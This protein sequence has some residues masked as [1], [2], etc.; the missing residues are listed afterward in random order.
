MARPKLLLLPE[1]TELEWA[2]R[3]KLEEW[4]EVIS[5]DL[6]GV[7]D[8][9]PAERLERRVIV[10]RALERLDRLGWDRC[11][12]A[13]DGWG[14]AS[15]VLTA[16]ERPDAVQ[17][18]ALGHT[19][20]SYRREG[21]RAPINAEVF[22]AIRQLID[23]DHEQFLRHGITQA[24]GGSVDEER[25]A[26]MVERF[27]K[28]LIR[29]GWDAVTRDD[30]DIGEL[31][32]R[33]DCPLLFAQ[34]KGCLGSTEEGFKDAVMAFPHARTVSVVEAPTTSETFAEALRSFCEEIA[35]REE[36]AASVRADLD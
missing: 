2:I 35:S 21:E 4:A 7:G 12:I 16:L 24:T 11:F 29:P 15:A 36:D 22:A 8:E 5:F 25:A 19:K 33:L 13:S 28:E 18:L 27:P 6:P 10:D 14:I 34:H 23:T 17:G 26:K 32:A 30:V 1:F 20:L 3:P 31:L 9:P